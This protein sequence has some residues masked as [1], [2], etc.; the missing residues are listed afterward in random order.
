ML[1]VYSLC[2]LFILDGTSIF[3]LFTYLEIEIFLLFV[4][5]V[6]L[7]SLYSAIIIRFLMF[8]F[9]IEEGK[10]STSS[11][12]FF[13]WQAQA[14]IYLFS[15]IYY[16]PFIPFVF[17]APFYRFYGARIGKGVAIGGK[18]VDI[19]LTTL[20]NHSGVGADAMVLGHLIAND[21][22]YIGKVTIE[23]HAM[24]GAKSLI[25]PGV[26][27]K[28]RATV[29]AM[30]LVTSGRTIPAGEIWVGSPAKLLKKIS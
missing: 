8:F 17:R 26:T 12:E 27:V 13:R 29:G 22:I 4:F 20:K 7:H 23:K 11:P 21:E 1:P 18:L 3:L 30:S 6:L 16:D 9:P 5:F 2:T 24:V 15:A 25:S 14:L 28:E 19:S 10:F